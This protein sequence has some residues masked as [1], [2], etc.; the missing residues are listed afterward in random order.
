MD[1]GHVDACDFCGSATMVP[2]MDSAI[3]SGMNGGCFA[4]SDALNALS[5]ASPRPPRGRLYKRSIAESKKAR[6]LLRTEM[7]FDP[8][9]N[10]MDPIDFD[11]GYCGVISLD[12]VGSGARRPRARNPGGPGG[13]RARAP[14][15]VG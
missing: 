5:S 2:Y 7:S 6:E 1:W 3:R 10:V 9:L 13:K 14:G 11:H 12:H 8:K 4:G 15:P